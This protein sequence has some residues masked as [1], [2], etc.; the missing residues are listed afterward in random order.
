MK[1][2]ILLALISAL[3]LSSAGCGKEKSEAVKNLETII[4]SIG[5]VPSENERIISEAIQ[6]Y[7]ALSEDEKDQIDS[8]LVDKLSSSIVSKIQNASKMSLA[9]AY[10]EAYAIETTNEALL[11]LQKDLS[12]LKSCEGTFYQDVGGYK[13][14]VTFWLQYGEYWFSIEYGGYMGTIA[15]K[16]IKQDRENGFL[17]ST[18]T[19][20]VHT[21]FF[22]GYLTT[23]DF[24][25]RFGSEKMYISWG[26]FCEYYLSRTK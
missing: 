1:K 20:G 6:A 2:V 11:Q 18:E 17:F 16:K 4:S 22:T 24:E 5:E 19:T 9:E 21:N 7:S 12:D 15:E 8:S 3:L 26:G 14:E 10:E 25:I 23:E 13:A